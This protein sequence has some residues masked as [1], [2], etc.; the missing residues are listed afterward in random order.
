MS[1]EGA[2]NS[3]E[4]YAG[5]EVFECQFERFALEHPW[6]GRRTG[7]LM[8]APRG[9]GLL[10]FQHAT[11][12]ALPDGGAH[13]V[14]GEILAWYLAHGGPGGTLGYPLSNEKRTPT[15]HG[16]YNSFEGGTVGWLPGV[17]AF[18]MG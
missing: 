4:T 3:S 18:L 7:D 14:H 6:I 16:R 10:E 17:G 11:V 9:G 12:F 1:V 2:V 13:E 5:L 8:L 15:G